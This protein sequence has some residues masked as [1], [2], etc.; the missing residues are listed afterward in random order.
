M[1]RLSEGCLAVLTALPVE[2][3]NR[4][5]L[6]PRGMTRLRPGRYSEGVAVGVQTLHDAVVS[7]RR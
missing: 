5:D 2:I 4:N 7:G 6:G 1:C 3:R